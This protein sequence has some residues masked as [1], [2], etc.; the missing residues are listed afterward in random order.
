MFAVLSRCTLQTPALV[1]IHEIFAQP[2][3]VARIAEA[4]V[5]LVLAEPACVAAVAVASEGVDSVDA[6]TVV[7]RRGLAVVDVCFAFESRESCRL[8]SDLFNILWL[9]W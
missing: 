9:L 6:V 3:V 4:L 8:M 2:T 7:A 5:D 1:P